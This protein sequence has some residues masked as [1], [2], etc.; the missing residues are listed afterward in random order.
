MERVILAINMGNDFNGDS[1][2]YK[3]EEIVNG[4]LEVKHIIYKRDGLQSINNR[5]D[6]ESCYL[7]VMVNELNKETVYKLI[8]ST[9]VQEVTFVEIEKEKDDS[10][11]VERVR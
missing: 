10:V 1:N 5:S 11:K 3:V 9:F 2:T 4:N 8:P 6:K 7:I